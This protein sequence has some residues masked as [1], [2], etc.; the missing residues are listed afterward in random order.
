MKG[1]S[2]DNIRVG[3]RYRLVNFSEIYEFVVEK[4]LGNDNFDLKDLHTLEPYQLQDL[5]RYGRGDDFEIREF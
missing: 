5:I 4:H 1:I 2:F 3:R